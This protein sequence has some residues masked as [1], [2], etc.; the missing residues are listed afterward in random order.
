MYCINCTE[1]QWRMQPY[2]L[3]VPFA[4]REEKKYIMNAYLLQWGNYKIGV[5]PK[6]SAFYQAL[7]SSANFYPNIHCFLLNTKLNTL[8]KW[9]GLYALVHVTTNR[10]C[11]SH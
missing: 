7:E 2:A 9:H 3:C 8:S 5:Q 4:T 6:R 1:F 11:Y 10:L